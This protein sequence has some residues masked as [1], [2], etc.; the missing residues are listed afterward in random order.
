MPPRDNDQ[1]N[2]PA[3]NYSVIEGPGVPAIRRG[4][5]ARLPLKMGI[6]GGGK[7]CDDLLTLLV[8]D[9]VSPLNIEILGVSDPNPEAPGMIHARRLSIYTTPDFRQLYDL[10]SLNFLIELTGSDTVREQIIK[11][12]PFEISFMDHRSSRLLWDLLQINTEKYQLQLGEIALQ[13]EVRRHK[14][15]LENIV[16]NSSDLIITT[17][18]ERHIVTFNPAGQR[19]LGY[20][21]EEMQ[22]NKVED[23]WI[24]PE[25]R[26]RLLSLVFSQGAVDNFPTTLKAKNGQGVDISLSLSLLRD[27]TGQ[28]IGTVGISKDITEENRLRRQLIENERLAA[29]GQTVAE[30]AHCIKN[31]LNGL[32]GGS[33]LINVGLKRKE[34]GLISE[35]WQTVQKS[36]SRISRLSLDMLNYSHDRKPDLQ[37]T[38]PFLLAKETTEMVFQAALL[39]GIEVGIKGQEGPPVFLDPTQIGRALLNLIDNAIDACREKDYLESEKP[40]VEVTVDRGDKE[41]RF[42][43]RDNGMGMD[44]EVQS[45][46]FKRFYSTKESG[47]TGLGLP[48]T[49]KIIN[50]HQGSLKWESIPGKGSVFSLLLPIQFPDPSIG[51]TSKQ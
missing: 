3:G 34:N 39:E 33:Y 14:E 4:T 45:Q 44:A 24:N 10:S 31:I 21:P 29:M 25:E 16:I 22:G 51:K 12:K 17:D 2:N 48:V 1:G 35:G 23:L 41:V 7:A 38:D 18:L 32:K 43:V 19:I 46:L 26:E 37:P 15:Y 49:Q 40:R 47:G 50:E 6:I 28:V 5:Q 8:E 13:E 9:H 11:T 20:S 36:I 30:L 27:N 42:I